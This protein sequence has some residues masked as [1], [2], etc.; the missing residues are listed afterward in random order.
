MQVDYSIF[1]LNLSEILSSRTAPQC[2]VQMWQTQNAT[3]AP[4][5]FGIMAAHSTRMVGKTLYKNVWFASVWIR[6]DKPQVSGALHCLRQ[7]P[8]TSGRTIMFPKWQFF[9][10][11]GHRNQCF[12]FACD[13]KTTNGGGTTEPNVFN[14]HCTN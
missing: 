7:V 12:R 6:K 5:V 1:K 9:G 4:R 3:K 10:N 11:F 8:L 2:F 13:V 14:Q